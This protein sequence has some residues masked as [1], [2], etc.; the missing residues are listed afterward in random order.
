M[1]ASDRT[2]FRRQFN[3]TSV[4]MWLLQR[5][6]AVL[7]GPLV[8]AHVWLPGMAG[9]RALNTLLLVI[10]VAHGFAGLNR[11]DVR[12][13]SAWRAKVVAIIWGVTVALLGAVVVLA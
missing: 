4:F 11:M 9:N 5:G 10:V 13:R 1:L 3:V 6:S 12:K 8:A 2:V 7:L